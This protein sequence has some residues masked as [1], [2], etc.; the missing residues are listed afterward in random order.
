MSILRTKSALILGSLGLSGGGVTGWRGQWPSEP[1]ASGPARPPPEGQEGGETLVQQA[2]DPLRRLRERA[3]WHRDRKPR[4]AA[5]Y[6][7][8]DRAG[9]EDLPLPPGLRRRARG[10]ARLR[11]SGGLRNRRQAAPRPGECGYI[12]AISG[13]SSG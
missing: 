13:G 10:H 7:G 2:G 9:P 3:P 6:R 12:E 4:T 5:G 1:S 11:Q 8:A